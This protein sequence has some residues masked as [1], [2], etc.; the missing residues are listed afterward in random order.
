MAEPKPSIITKFLSLFRSAEE[1]FCPER[2][3]DTGDPFA[4]DVDEILLRGRSKVDEAWDRIRDLTTRGNAVGAIAALTVFGSQQ[5][6]G[7][8]PR[9]WLVGTVV[10]FLVGLAALLSQKLFV[11]LR[12]SYETAV[13]VNKVRDTTFR[14]PRIVR[15]IFRACDYLAVITLVLG[16]FIGISILFALTS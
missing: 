10:V 3:E 2:D 9:R 13:E 8:T 14:P 11:P 4:A 1:P 6:T 7:G 5:L 12:V 15:I 16:T